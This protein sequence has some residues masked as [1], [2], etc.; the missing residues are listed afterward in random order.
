MFTPSLPSQIDT[1]YRPDDPRR[2]WAYNVYYV[3]I[4][5]GGFL[6]PLICGTLGELYGWHWGFAA[7]GVGMLTGLVIYISGGKYLPD[8]ARA[9]EAIAAPD[10]APTAP[11]ARAGDFLA[12]DPRPRPPSAPPPPPSDSQQLMLARP[13]ADQPPPFSFGY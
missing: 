10:A 9:A 1:L 7:A 11:V 8:Q 6:A 2:G 12:R 13:L 3:G 4:N 5:I